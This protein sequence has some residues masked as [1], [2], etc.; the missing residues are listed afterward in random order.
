[1]ENEEKVEIVQEVIEETPSFAQQE[2]RN[3]TMAEKL[4]KSYKYFWISLILWPFICCCCLPGLSV[5]VPFLAARS[6]EGVLGAVIFLLLFF[7]LGAFA[8][9]FPAILL[10]MLYY[11]YW[12]IIPSSEA[13]GMTPAKALGFLFIPY[14][15]CYWSFKSL[16]ALGLVMEKLQAQIKGEEEKRTLLS[17]VPFFYSLLNI[18]MLVLGAGIF[19]FAK[20]A[21]TAGTAGMSVDFTSFSSSTI[22]YLLLQIVVYLFSLASL[23]LGIIMLVEFQKGALF[24]LRSPHYAWQANPP[25]SKTPIFWGIFFWLLITVITAV[26][27]IPSTSNVIKELSCKSRVQALSY[28]LGMYNET[29]KCLPPSLALLPGKKGA[30]L[31]SCKMG[32]K[33]VP[34]TYTPAPLPKKGETKCLLSCPAHPQHQIFLEERS[35]KY[36][37]IRDV[38]N[39]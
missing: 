1:M 35:G 27:S 31:T 13:K 37:V 33:K 23:V 5:L 18:I 4:R 9:G 16:W 2:E 6:G 21:G 8:L 7:L 26:F 22:F 36:R 14:F 38:K 28:E 3:L 32:G 19:I 30:K 10:C 25:A 17:K 12:K 24:L 34:Y 15:S 11:R 20:M 39:K 29:H